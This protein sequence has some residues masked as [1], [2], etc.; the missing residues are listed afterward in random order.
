MDSH[1]FN[2]E[3]HQTLDYSFP[4]GKTGQLLN[5]LENYTERSDTIA[6][7]QTIK[8][9]LKPLILNIKDVE[10][11]NRQ[12]TSHF[13]C[14]LNLHTGERYYTDEFSWTRGD[15][16]TLILLYKAD[17]VF[18]ETTYEFIANTIG[19]VVA[20]RKSLLAVN[21]NPFIRTGT[22]GIALCFKILYRLSEKSFY[23]EAESYWLSETQRQKAKNNTES[24]T[25]SLLDGYM[26]VNLVLSSME[27]NS[28]KSELEHLLMK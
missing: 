19:A 8:Q 16:V 12:T 5:L 7:K 15:L 14:E 21:D 24:S 10:Y 1:N 25:N 6:M 2:T 20:Q 4:D 26:G 18:G 28:T 22:A 9:H 23:R 11:A 13:P 3:I 27:W 17:K